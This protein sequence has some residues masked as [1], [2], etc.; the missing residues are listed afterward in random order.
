MAAKIVNPS[1]P[2]IN[3]QLRFLLAHHPA[4]YSEDRT[5]G[6]HPIQQKLEN[7]KDAG[8]LYGRIIYQKAPVV[9]NQLEQIVGEE[10][11]REGLREYLKNYSFGNAEWDDLINI[12][13]KKSTV[14]L[15]EW[16]EAW[17]KEA[18]MPQYTVQSNVNNNRLKSLK[19]QQKKMINTGTLWQQKVSVALVEGDKKEQISVMLSKMNTEVKGVSGSIKPD[20]ILV[21]SDGTGYGYFGLDDASR[22]YLMQHVYEIKD[23]VLRGGA[24][25][26]LYEEVLR[27]QITY[28]AFM[29]V[30]MQALPKE[31]EPLN[32]Q[33]LLGY[34][35]E[36]Y[37]QYYTE[38]ERELIAEKLEKLLWK[39]MD[40]SP[41]QSA[42]AAYFKTYLKI[43]ETEE[44]V[45][46]LKLIWDGDLLM[47]D[48]VLS[49]RD[50]TEIACEIAL[51]NPTIADE[52]LQKQLERINNPDRKARLQFV[53]PAL[54]TKQA[55]RDLF[56]ETLKDKANRTHEPWVIEALSY[57]HHPLRAKTSE[58]YL[59]ESLIL[60]EEIQQSGDIFFPKRW[61]VSIFSGHQSKSAALIVKKFLDERPNY[62]YRLKNKILQAADPLF[63][64]AGVDV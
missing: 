14:N 11:F 18:G 3:H 36:V 2:E 52:I 54:S 19:I 50:F 25:I 62:P 47:N 56:F 61:L 38:K 31:N 40:T 33:N 5:G 23:P 64:A 27:G 35:E 37:W 24:W 8:T 53:I 41:G 43:A 22:Q 28:A 60:L 46:R 21:N 4:A 39:I 30:L 34:L 26:A 1:F 59:E 10:K 58:K 29:E 6:S 44:A 12:L 16:S 13:E 55:D 48:M 20:F 7:L 63:R 15:S 51:R 9:M 32:T 42:K 17:V 57:L 45:T 49:E